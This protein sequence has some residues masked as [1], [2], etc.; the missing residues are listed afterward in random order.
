MANRF[1]MQSTMRALVIILFATSVLP[2]TKTTVNGTSVLTLVVTDTAIADLFNSYQKRPHVRATPI[3]APG[4]PETSTTHGFT[5]R[6][7]EMGMLVKT[8]STALEAITSVTRNSALALG[9]S[10][11]CRRVAP[12]KIA[13]LHILTAHSAIYIRHAPSNQCLT[14]GSTLQQRRRP[15]GK[16]A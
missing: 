9:P 10:N 16:N 4:F 2:Q 8:G 7:S 5:N 1:L 12:G 13:N 14:N 15:I 6:H 11:C 3:A